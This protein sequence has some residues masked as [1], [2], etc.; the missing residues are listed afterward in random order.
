MSAVAFSTA[1]FADDSLNAPIIDVD[2]KYLSSVSCLFIS[3]SFFDSFAS[4]K[5][6]AV[7]FN[8]S[9]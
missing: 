4:I 6:F 5:A 8:F 3:A 2:F 7:L 9:Y 1:F